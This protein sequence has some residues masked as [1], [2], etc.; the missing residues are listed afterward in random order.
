MLPS[1]RFAI[2][3]KLLRWYQHH[4]RDLPWRRTQDAY[5]IWISETMLQQTQVSTVIPYY[6]KF[7]ANLPSVEALALAPLAKVLRLWSGLGYY[8]RAANLRAAAQTIVREHR[9]RIPQ[10]FN[11]L[12]ALPGIG[13]YSAGAL[14]SIAFGLRHAAIDGNARRVLSRLLG[15]TD[16]RALRALAAELVPKSRPGDFNQALMELGAIVCTPKNQ[17]CSDCAVNSLCVSR[18][19]PHSPKAFSSRP[20]V[21]FKSVI[22]PLAIVR[23]GG[24]ILLRRRG[25][26]GLLASLWELPGGERNSKELDTTFLRRELREAGLGVTRFEKFAEIRHAITYRRIRAPIYLFDVAAKEPMKL[27]QSRWRWVAPAKLKELAASSITAKAVA[28]LLSS[29]EK[30]IH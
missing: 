10:D 19:R 15:I 2:R 12:R 26:T 17:S 11:Q 27:S 5:A 9:G 29:H 28:A 24:K 16:E 8:R 1:L 13:D 6:E 21:K 7:L 3:R 30:T 14:A 25:A 20:R 23:R 4:K 22:W 18:A